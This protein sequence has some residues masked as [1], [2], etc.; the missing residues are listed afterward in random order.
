MPSS[1]S[2]ID[3]INRALAKIGDQRITSRGDNNNRARLMD[4][5]YDGIRD[6]LLR[7]CPWNFATKRTTLAADP[8]TPVYQWGTAFAIPADLLYMVSTENSSAYRLEGNQILSNQENSLKITY[9]RRVTDPTEFDTGFAELLAAKLAY[10]GASNI[11][12]DLALQDRLFREYNLTLIRSKKTDG[13][14][15]DSREWAIDDWELA[16]SGGRFS[17]TDII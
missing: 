8:T 7:E 11:A 5:L 13:Q 16:R 14:E 2:E 12:A 4:S 9:I 10:E 3:I 1:L 17:D 15:D 6:E